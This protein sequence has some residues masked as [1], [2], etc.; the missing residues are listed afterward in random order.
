VT[1]LWGCAF[2]DNE[3]LLKITIPQNVK[4]ISNDILSGGNPGVVV[5]GAANSAAETF[6]KQ[7]GYKFD[8]SE[9]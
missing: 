6:A 1:D 7:C 5:Y 2:C 3:N 9:L 4:R 8:G